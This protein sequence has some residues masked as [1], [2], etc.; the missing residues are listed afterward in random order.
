MLACAIVFSFSASAQILNAAKVPAVVK[1]SFTKQFPVAKDVTWEKK[2]VTYE[3]G[4]KN[5]TQV[6]TVILDPKGK[7]LE[8]QTA[9]E[10]KAIPAV[11]VK[12]VKSK[13]KGK[14]IIG[15]VKVVA[16]T[17]MT[18]EVMIES[19]KK[20]IFDCQGNFISAAKF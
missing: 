18:Y 15:A 11:I 7:L 16:G 13:F 1:A 4:L 2:G 9:L 5:K 3:V 12:Y 6:M 10:N 17:K 8:S 14:G 19:G 20:L